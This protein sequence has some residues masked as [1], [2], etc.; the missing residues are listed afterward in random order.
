MCPGPFLRP[1]QRAGRR[2]GTGACFMPAG[3]MTETQRKT[4][5][6]AERLAKGRTAR[7]S[8][9]VVPRLCLVWGTRGRS[10]R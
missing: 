9:A 5:L 8:L 2:L 6:E 7:M 3:L 1:K 10:F 4:L